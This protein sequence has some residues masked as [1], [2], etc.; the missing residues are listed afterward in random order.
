MFVEQYVQKNRYLAWKFWKNRKKHFLSSRWLQS[1]LKQFCDQIWALKLGFLALSTVLKIPKLSEMTQKCS[2]CSM[3][4]STVATCQFQILDRWSKFRFSVQGEYHMLWLHTLYVP[5]HLDRKS[6]R[7][8]RLAWLEN[9]PKITHFPEIVL[10]DPKK[11]QKFFL[12]K[13]LFEDHHAYH[14]YL[15]TAAGVLWGLKLNQAVRIR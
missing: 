2:Y 6:H 5:L 3:D 9:T 15:L 1:L 14:K 10:A 7:Q 11:F 4:V 13:F 8:W 12:Q